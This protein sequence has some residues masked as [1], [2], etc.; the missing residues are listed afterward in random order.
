[1]AVSAGLGVVEF[2]EVTR[3]LK[4]D[5]KLILATISDAL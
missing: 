4:I 3:V 5:G 1:M 2:L